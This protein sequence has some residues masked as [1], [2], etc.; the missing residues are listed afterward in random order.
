MSYPA[1]VSYFLRRLQGYHTNVF[2][3]M[4]QNTDSATSGKIIHV[5]LPTNALLNMKSFAMHFDASATEVG[6]AGVARL[7]NKITSLIDRVEVLMGGITVQQGFNQYNT[8]VHI[9]ENLSLNDDNL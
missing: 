9:K 7:P 1:N 3:L 4:P 6:G 8:A 2:K 5:N